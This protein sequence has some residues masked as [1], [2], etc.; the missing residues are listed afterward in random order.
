MDLEDDTI[1]VEG[2]KSNLRTKESDIYVMP[3]EEE[4]KTQRKDTDERYD[5]ERNE[6]I[7]YHK[8]EVQCS[9]IYEKHEKEKYYGHF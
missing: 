1:L 9:V 6:A 4:E 3:L 2:K 5:K 8:E 7:E